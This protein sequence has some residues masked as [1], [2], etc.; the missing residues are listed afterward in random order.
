MEQ[1]SKPA[2]KR[3]GNESKPTADLRAKRL[4][5]LKQVV[6]RMMKACIPEYKECAIE[7]IIRDCLS[8]GPSSTGSGNAETE[9]WN[10]SAEHVPNLSSEKILPGEEHAVHLDVLFE[11]KLPKSMNSQDK[12]LIGIEIQNDF[13]SIDKLIA[14]GIFYLA[15]MT[16]SQYGERFQAPHYGKMIPVCSIWV[17]PMAPK[18]LASTILT[19][20]NVIEVEPKEKQQEIQK[21]L[22]HKMSQTL[23]AINL[24]GDVKPPDDIRGFLWTLMH[25]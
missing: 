16:V 2:R 7:E 5:S 25:P 4:F 8:P 3:K 20:H 17:C 24:N 19:I 9:P 15:V 10:D 22:D 18:K 23:V 6:A 11:A 1:N 12:M 13:K 21:H 14:R